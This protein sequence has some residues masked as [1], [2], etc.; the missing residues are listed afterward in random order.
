MA[1]LKSGDIPM[2]HSK[3]TVCLLFQICIFKE[4]YFVLADPWIV[5]AAEYACDK[6]ISSPS[7]EISKRL[8]MCSNLVGVA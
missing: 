6:N 4:R 2:R 1:S 5:E 3:L 8:I 7:D